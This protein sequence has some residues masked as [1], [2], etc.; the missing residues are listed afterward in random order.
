MTDLIRLRAPRGTSECSHNTSLYLV[1]ENGCV[2]V[3]P[4]AV[5]P[6]LRVGGF[7]VEPPAPED[8]PPALADVAALVR[9]M[10]D[11]PEKIAL[12][13]AIEAAT[14]DP[15][16]TND[17]PSPEDDPPQTLAAVAAPA[18]VGLSIPA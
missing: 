15:A 14:A 16:D 4:E 18:L 9:S 3:P 7:T 5:E 10:S 8:V 1:R 2:D 6:L 11:G 12:L 17:E 13:A